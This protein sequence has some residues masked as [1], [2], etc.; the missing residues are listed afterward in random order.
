MSNGPRAQ[1]VQRKGP[2]LGVA[3][4]VLGLLGVVATFLPMD[5]SGVRHYVAWL[6]GLPG[7]V[8]AIFGLLGNRSGKP[9]AVIGA[10]LSLFAVLIGSI[11]IAN[12]IGIF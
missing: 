6:F 4:L 2:W 1:V 11:A 12:V 10:L 3:A 5:L 8:L 9:F 7:F